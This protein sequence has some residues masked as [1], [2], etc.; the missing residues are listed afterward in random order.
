[1]HEKY[2]MESHAQKPGCLSHAGFRRNAVKNM[3]LSVGHSE[4][5]E[6]LPALSWKMSAPC[7]LELE[8]WPC[9]MAMSLGGGCRE[10]PGYRQNLSVW[11]ENINAVWV[12]E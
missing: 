11:D 7:R 12:S 2:N 9:L 8:V 10:V 1:M 4:T 5:N 6:G 3:S